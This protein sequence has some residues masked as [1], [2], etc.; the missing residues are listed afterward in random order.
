VEIGDGFFGV[1][2]IRKWFP[3]VVVRWIALP[4]YFVKGAFPHQF[5]IID[6]IHFE[7]GYVVDD[8]G[9]RGCVSNC[10]AGRRRGLIGRQQRLIEDRMKAGPSARQF[11]LVGRQTVLLN[12][13]EGAIP[14]RC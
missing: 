5:E 3:S 7:L 2:E 8:D 10:L 13:G 12:Y 14:L 11:Q 6:G 9:G 1:V 4:M